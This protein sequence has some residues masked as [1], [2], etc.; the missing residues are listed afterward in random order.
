M[1]NERCW[2]RALDD[3]SEKI[4]GEHR[5]AVAA[6]PAKNIDANRAERLRGGVDLQFTP[7]AGSKRRPIRAKLNLASLVVKNL[8]TRHNSL[9]SELDDEAG[10]FTRALREFHNTAVGRRPGRHWTKIHWRLNRNLIERWFLKTAIVNAEGCGLPIGGPDAVADEPIRHLVNAVFGLESTKG[11]VGLWSLPRVGQQIYT[12]PEFV[13]YFQERVAPAPAERRFVSACFL[14]YMQHRFL[15]C[16]DPTLPLNNS[17]TIRGT[18]V[19][20]DGASLLR[21]V[22]NLAAPAIGLELSFHE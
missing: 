18:E 5:I 16:L 15:V 9:L 21:P 12:K 4:S 20:W 3:C 1:K 22:P 13:F 2:A 17:E 8:C 14:E 10:R 7:A 11:P 19:G 6:W